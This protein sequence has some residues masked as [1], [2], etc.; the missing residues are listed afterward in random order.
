M[1][2]KYG[3]AKYMRDCGARVV[4][5][6]DE[7][8]PIRGLRGARL[9]RKELPDEPEPIIYLDMVNSSPEPDGSFRRYLERIDPKAYGAVAA[10]SCWAAMASR[11]RYRDESG[12]LQMT[13]QDYREYRPAAET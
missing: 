2:E 13:F 11:W 10:R 9:L 5:E 7:T 3:W 6:V 8:H 1:L 4:D 12:A